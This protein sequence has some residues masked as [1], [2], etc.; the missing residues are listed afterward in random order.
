MST[1]EVEK[2]N[3]EGLTDTSVRHDVPFVRLELFDCVHGI[4]RLKAL[5][6]LLYVPEGM[7]PRMLHPDVTVRRAASLFAR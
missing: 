5:W 3:D 2:D 4:I 1:V 6:T 7:N